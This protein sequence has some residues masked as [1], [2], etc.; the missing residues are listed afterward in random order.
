MKN[1]SQFAHEDSQD[2]LPE[3]LHFILTP[4]V[5]LFIVGV[6]SVIYLRV[7]SNNSKTPGSAYRKGIGLFFVPFLFFAYNQAK[8]AA[9]VSLL[10]C[11]YLA[12]KWI[13]RMGKGNID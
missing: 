10:A 12:I 6:V 9:L 7:I 1:L 3:S 13:V 11:L 5:S 8:T 4:A 2:I